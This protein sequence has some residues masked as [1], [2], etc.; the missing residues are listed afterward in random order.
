[1]QEVGLLGTED[2]IAMIKVWLALEVR[3]FIS[4]SIQDVSIC[5]LDCVNE[6]WMILTLCNSDLQTCQVGW[7]VSELLEIMCA[8]TNAMTFMNGDGL[9][10][11]WVKQVLVRLR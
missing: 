6:T 8:H 3:Q 5:R 7:T 11:R 2:K 1:M 4:L 9:R 10:S